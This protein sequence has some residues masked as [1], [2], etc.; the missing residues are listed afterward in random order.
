MGGADSHSLSRLRFCPRTKLCAA[1]HN[2]CRI[3]G[4]GAPMVA[5]EVLAYLSTIISVAYAG[6]L[7]GYSLGVFTLSHA[8]TNI[9]GGQLRPS[10]KPGGLWVELGNSLGSQ[11]PAAQLPYCSKQQ[12]ST[13]P[14]P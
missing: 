7:G 3:L 5:E 6:R 13:A 14:F 11:M 4:I 8:L 10:R 12:C 2:V 1:P 9:T